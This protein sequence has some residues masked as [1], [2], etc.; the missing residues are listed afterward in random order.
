MLVDK[1]VIDFLNETASN[2]PVPGGGSIAA[3][4]GATAA[5]LTEMVANLTIGRKGYEAISDEMKQ[6]AERANEI[7]NQLIKDIDRDAEAFNDVM[8][9]F[10]YPKNTDEEKVIR[11]EKIQDS[12]KHAAMV[13][14][15]VAKKSYEIIDLAKVVVEKGNQNAVTDGAV[16]SMMARTAVLSALYNVKINLGSI[17]DSEFVDE[18][19]KEVNNL[20]TQVI[21]KEQQILESVEL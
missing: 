16:A 8:A 10:K 17:K 5:A 7:R 21:V 3:H 18:I 1:T 13:P 2:N 19:S 9:A 6:I 20:E 12:M 11:K 14:L 15:E 4:S